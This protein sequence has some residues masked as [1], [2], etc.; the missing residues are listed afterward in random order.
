MKRR[1]QKV[2]IIGLA[3]NVKKRNM[4]SWIMGLACRLYIGCGSGKESRVEKC[5]R[6]SSKV[7]GRERGI[8]SVGLEKGN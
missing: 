5:S 6:I 7:L 3:G 2:M 8:D 4:V 1:N